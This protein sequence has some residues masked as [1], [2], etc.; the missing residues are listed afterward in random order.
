MSWNGY[1]DPKSDTEPVCNLHVELGRLEAR[2]RILL[3][4]VAALLGIAR[5][6]TPWWPL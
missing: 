4:M 1:G 3:V 6:A 2:F 5:R